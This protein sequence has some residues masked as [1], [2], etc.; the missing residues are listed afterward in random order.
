MDGLD[1]LKVK[2]LTSVANAADEAIQVVAWTWR[3]NPA[4]PGGGDWQRWHW[5]CAEIND[6]GI[7]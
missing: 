2:Y 7:V 4:R 1:A 5:Q 3:G 6:G